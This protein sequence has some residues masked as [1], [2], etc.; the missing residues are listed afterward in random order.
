MWAGGFFLPLPWCFFSHCCS[1][2]SDTIE[3]FPHRPLFFLPFG[4]NLDRYGLSK[5]SF[6]EFPWSCQLGISTQPL[7]IFLWLH[8]VPLKPFSHLQL[9]PKITFPALLFPFSCLIF[10]FF[11]LVFF[12]FPVLFFHFPCSVENIFKQLQN[13]GP[14]SDFWV[15]R[16]MF[17][18][19]LGCWRDGK[20]FFLP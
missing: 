17:S 5:Y 11:Y 12:T 10:N 1:L 7:K 13:P 8:R 6:E 19:I 16:G 14:S 9:S 2:N 20:G 4:D 18:P 3:L 15:G